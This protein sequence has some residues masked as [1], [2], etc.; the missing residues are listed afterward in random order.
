MRVRSTTLSLA[1]VLGVM[2]IGGLGFAASDSS[3]EGGEKMADTSK[4][5]MVYARVIDESG[6]L[7]EK[8]VFTPKV[9]R[10]DEEWKKILTPE[11]FRIMRNQGTEPAFCGGL[12]KN[13]EEGLYLCLGCNLPLFASNAK[14]ESGTGWPSFFQPVGNTN[15]L[16]RADLS[17]GMVRTEILCY[18]CESHLG[19]LFPDGPEPTGLRYC[20]NSESLKFAAVADYK[21]FGEKFEK[22]EVAEA[23]IAGGCFWCVE[24]VFE[25]IDG[26]LEAVSGYSG[27]DAKTANYQA[28]C[29]GKTDHAEAVRIVYDP[30]KLSYEEILK[31]HFATHDPTTLNRQGNDVGT[32]YRS[33]IFPHDEE[34]RAEA[35]TGIERAQADW[36]D[37]IVTAIEPLGVWYPAEDYHQQY[38]DRV[39]TRNPY[40]M[41]VIPPKLQKLR[42]G[43]ADRLRADA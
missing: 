33:A 23:V 28:V 42:K 18:R 6:R 27:G 36:S 43:F 12:L 3:T 13:K 7:T 4:T 29:T 11:Q 22:T 19:H 1:G 37:P 21:K 20:L 32:Q 31:I 8:P 24:G 2:L 26:I 9:I 17:H 16:E 38:W 14:F 10:S 5:P 25:E 34:Q 41:A 15:I 39:G 30:K 40:C 35:V